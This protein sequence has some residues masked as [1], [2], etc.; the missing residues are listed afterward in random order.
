MSIWVI[1]FLLGMKNLLSSE[2]TVYLADFFQYLFQASAEQD[3]SSLIKLIKIILLSFLSPK[4]LRLIPVFIIPYLWALDSAS[5]YLANVFE[6]DNQEIARE[7]IN[8]AAFGSRY[9]TLL[10]KDGAVADKDQHSHLLHIGGPG[11]VKVDLH[12]VALF[13]KP[14][15]RPHVIGP[16]VQAN[17][18]E[19]RLEGFERLRATLDL[20]DIVVGP[21]NIGGR[22]QDGI[23]I[24]AEDVR[25]VFSVWRGVTPEERTPTKTRAYPFRKEAIP[26]LVYSQ[27]CHA[28]QA[29]GENPLCSDWIDTTRAHIITEMKHFIADTN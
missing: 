19:N 4:I 16:T 22:T 1:W 12:S 8:R 7:F 29:E 25:M 14:N 9:E 21:L 24:N 26:N 3:S 17:S 5:K 13:E 10:I 2:W 6:L 27:S 15:G 28:E 23:K 11:L 18:G 20:R